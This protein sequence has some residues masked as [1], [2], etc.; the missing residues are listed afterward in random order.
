MAFARQQDKQTSLCSLT[1]DSTRPST[2]NF[3]GHTIR[4]SWRSLHNVRASLYALNGGAVMRAPRVTPA[5]VLGDP[6]LATA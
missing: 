5:L 6:I 1:R 2:L 4:C 3:S